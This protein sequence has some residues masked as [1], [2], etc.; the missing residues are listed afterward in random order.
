MEIKKT[1]PG[2]SRFVES[3]TAKGDSGGAVNAAIRGLQREAQSVGAFVEAAGGL[4]KSV[5]R[6]GLAL[7]AASEREAVRAEERAEDNRQIER[8]AAAEELAAERQSIIDSKL[9]EKRKRDANLSVDIKLYSLQANSAVDELINSKIGRINFLE[10]NDGKFRD[11]IN[12]LLD[13]T[14]SEVEADLMKRG[15][16]RDWNQESYEKT[17]RALDIIFEGT[18]SNLYEQ[19][20]KSIRNDA[21]GRAN[22]V[23]ENLSAAG[24]EDEAQYASAYE[25]LSANGFSEDQIK[26]FTEIALKKGVSVAF[27]NALSLSLGQASNAFQTLFFENVQSGM[28][29]SSAA[30]AAYEASR[31]ILVSPFWNEKEGVSDFYRSK[32]ERFGLESDFNKAIMNA[33]AKLL[34]LRDSV[35][36]ATNSQISNDVKAFMS[37]TS[38]SLTYPESYRFFRYYRFL[39]T[40]HSEDAE[41]SAQIANVFTGG[42]ADLPKKARGMSAQ[43][44]S[45]FTT[46]LLNDMALLDMSKERDRAQAEKILKYSLLL[47]E[48]D[49]ASIL[50]AFRNS[51]LEI[52]EHKQR[53][54]KARIAEA[55]SYADDRF[56][57][58]KDEKNQLTGYLLEVSKLH[59]GANIEAYIQPAIEEWRKRTVAQKASGGMIAMLLGESEDNRNTGIDRIKFMLNQ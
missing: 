33:D 36:E 1:Q 26:A 16:I 39:G 47:P 31:K 30:K 2:A 13:E 44:A 23:A 34:R 9:R 18:A 59:G 28:S 20:R 43:D 19:R 46:Y 5:L 21:L 42:E 6:G 48:T 55:V 8:R 49:R 56:D 52:G 10:S 4:A 50:D 35:K 58:S 32:T 25:G 38:D 7:S 3:R 51:V 24:V 57:L 45:D 53:A 22:V 29:T 41:T 15:T 14:R 37:G 12:L 27:D 40:A 17:K 11:D 54:D